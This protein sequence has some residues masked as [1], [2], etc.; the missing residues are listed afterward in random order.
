M[1]PPEVTGASYQPTDIALL[2][3]HIDR[4]VVAMQRS[5]AAVRPA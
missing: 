3:A 1:S 5:H 2:A 4:P